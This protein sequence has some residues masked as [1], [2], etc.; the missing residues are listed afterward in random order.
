MRLADLSIRSGLSAAA[1]VGAAMLA[2]SMT[3]VEVP[4]AA[5]SLAAVIPTRFADWREVK[6][7]VA[8][9]SPTVN[10]DAARDINNPYDEIVMRTY[11]NSRGET[12]FLAL[13]Y[14]ANQ[15]Q[16]D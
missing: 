5:G 13:A 15:R 6:S 12:V 16:E 10:Q 3:P 8:Q 2:G 7:D 11:S 9:V 14:G 1:M 4:Y